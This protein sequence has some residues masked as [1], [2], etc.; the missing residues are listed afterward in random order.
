MSVSRKPAIDRRDRFAQE[1]TKDF[2][3]TQAAIRAG[4]SAKTAKQQ[5]SRLLT[6]VDVR[7]Q[8]ESLNLAAAQAQGITRERTLHEIGNV[9]YGDLRALF[10]KGGNLKQITELS[11][12]EAAQLGGVEIETVTTQAKDGAS[13]T[14]TKV[15]KV[16]VRDKVAALRLCVDVLGLAKPVDPAS[17]TGGLRITIFGHGGR[18][19]KA[20]GDDA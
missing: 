9:A 1:Y 2:N 14:S 3:A 5:G 12:A 4:Y 15:K 6:D 11:A 20:A 16:R 13:S 8:I 19:V 7:A 18:S 10:Q 17:A